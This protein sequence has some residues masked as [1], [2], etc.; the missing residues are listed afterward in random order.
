MEP[1]FW[2]LANRTAETQFI[3]SLFHLLLAGL[4]LLLWLHQLRNP[5]ADRRPEYTWL[6]PGGF[7]LLVL[8]F[9]L[10]TLYFGMEF[11]FRRELEWRGLEGIARGLIACGLLLVTAGLNDDDPGHNLPLRHR[12][13]TAYAVIAGLVLLDF[14]VPRLPSSLGK[15]AAPLPLLLIDLLAFT[16]VVLGMRALIKVKNSGWKSNL[17]ALGFAGIGLL[18]HHT[19]AL[20]SHK[21]GILFWNAEQHVLSC[22]LFAFAWAA[23]EHSRNLLDRIF[24]RLNLTF[25][26]LASMIMLMTAGMEKYQYLRLTEERSMELAEFI[27]GHVVY[28]RTQGENLEDIL[29]HKQ[30]LRRIVSGFSTLPELREVDI[31]VGGRRASFRYSPDW[32]IHEEIQPVAARVPEPMPLDRAGSFQMVS[33]RIGGATDAGDRVDFRGSMDLINE[34]IGKY[35]IMIYSLFT[36]MVALASTVVGIIVNDADRQLRQ[37]FAELQQTQQQLAQ[38]AKLASI[39]E[40]A[41][42]MAHEINTPIT[43]ILSLASHL[44]EN[45]NQELGTRQRKSLQLVAQEAERVSRIVGNL[46]TFARR[47]RLEVSRV[48]VPELLD[49]ATQLIQ[50][51]LR[52][53][54]IRLRSELE[55][56]LP[57]VL[58]DAGRLTEVFVNVLN[59]AIDAMPERGL[60]TLRACS[61]PAPEK[62]VRIGITDTGCGIPATQLP[63]IFDP[64]FTTKEP[65]RGT[66]LGL[67]ISHGIIKDH[68][69]QIWAE[70]QPGVGTTLWV[71]LP[72]GG[73]SV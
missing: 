4:T 62:T 45:D 40:L 13:G 69:G 14:V 59:N 21:A 35:L 32:E 58:G 71:T 15:F 31:Y 28:Y 66:G 10:A 6:L 53:G 30:V 56:N 54:T 26:V 7:L 3:F 22:A 73:S 57:P 55:A 38:A 42:G 24:V 18:L 19:P 20:V 67:S 29:G 60:L 47:S 44:A 64:F 65:G 16:A 63:L 33:L 27:R 25:I 51:R 52:D 39:G 12:L 61:T 11:F 2:Q 36:V 46:L 5:R 37:Q 49:T 17:I 41:G 34:Y 48:D 72:A 70:S 50:F 9:G 1:L 23:G 43:S 68:G 8:Q